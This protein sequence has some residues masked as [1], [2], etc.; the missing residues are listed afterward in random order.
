MELPEPKP[1]GQEYSAWLEAQG[2]DHPVLAAFN[3]A[4]FD[5][6]EPASNQSLAEWIEAAPPISSWAVVMDGQ[7]FEKGAMGWFGMSSDNKANW[8]D[9][10]NDLFGLIRDDQWVAVVDCHI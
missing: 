6:P 4:C 10:F 7:W 8:E 5:L 1:R 2:G 9:H 3:R